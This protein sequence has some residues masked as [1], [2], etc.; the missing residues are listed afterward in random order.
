[1]SE[2]LLDAEGR[3]EGIGGSLSLEALRRRLPGLTSL[4]GL[5]VG[6]ARARELPA[7]EAG[8]DVD[9]LRGALAEVTRVGGGKGRLGAAVKPLCKND[10]R[11]G[12]RA[13]AEGAVLARLHAALGL[14]NRRGS[15][16]TRGL[17]L[18][19]L[20]DAALKLA[21]V[22]GV[23]ARVVLHGAGALEGG[24]Q[25]PKG[26]AVDLKR[27]VGVASLGDNGGGAAEGAGERLD[28][29]TALAWDNSG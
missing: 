12:A 10:A 20:A 9:V 19:T 1:M 7:D 5:L 6:A 26:G 11:V 24:V 18:A 16:A 15:V 29:S 23:G 2:R 28:V 3:V 14:G 13:E 17:L 22:G 27:A 8:D 21:R 25:V 4:N